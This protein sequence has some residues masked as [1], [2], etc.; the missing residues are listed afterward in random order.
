MGTLKATPKTAGKMVTGITDQGEGKHPSPQL[1]ADES[2]NAVSLMSDC[3]MIKRG[4]VCDL[5]DGYELW[6]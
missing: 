4:A 3:R 5:C 2:G 1:R 6:N